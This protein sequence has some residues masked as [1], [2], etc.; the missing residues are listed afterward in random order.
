MTTLLLSH[1]AYALH[2]TGPH[3]PERP[4][5]IRAILQALGG[6]HFVMLHRAD[7]PIVDRAALLRVHPA[8]YIDAIEAA[9]QKRGKVYLD[10]D[11]VMSESSY[12]AIARSAGGAAL[13]VEKVM[14]GGA[15]NAFVAM[16][17]PGHHAGMASPMGFCF[18]NN[19]AI[20]AR[21]A[22]AAH[23]AER[24]AIL[25][26]DVHHGNGTQEIFWSD[27]SVLYAS[28]HQMPLF[29]GTGGD[30]ECGD[31][32]TI[33]NVPLSAGDNGARFRAELDQKV[34]PRIDEFRPDMIV[35]SAGFD[36]HGRDPL[37]GLNLVEDD[38]AWATA[39]VMEIAEKRAKGRIVSVLEGGYDLE[40]LSRSVAAHVLTLMS[41]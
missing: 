34:L 36:A 8:R 6:E 1:P 32:G 37:G 35:I 24:V 21:H 20:A 16:R 10:P 27:P 33:V 19:A 40:G 17:P 5:R 28:T 4:D 38:F 7:A 2:D 30:S 3:H 31:Y 12:E 9:G 41:A 15:K 13:A 39:R 23:G 25:D 18:F 14:T 11:T 22:Q 29:P 26:F